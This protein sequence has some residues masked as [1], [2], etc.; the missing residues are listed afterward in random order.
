[1]QKKRSSYFHCL[2]CSII[3]VMMTAAVLSGCYKKEA[4]KQQAS[5]VPVRTAQ[6]KQEDVQL[7]YYFTGKTDSVTVDVVPRIRGYLEECL[8]QQGELVDKGQILYKIEQFDYINDIDN[9]KAKLEIAK[10]KAAN[11]RADYD[12]NLELQ[13]KGAG[14]TTQAD[15]DKTKALWEESVG[16]I[17]SAQATLQ[18]AEKQLERT[19]I[20]AP[21][22]G[23]ISR[24]LIDPGNLV[25]GSTGTPPLLATIRGMD[26]IQV[27]FQVTDTE[28]NLIMS[29]MR[30]FLGDIKKKNP[31][32]ER[33]PLIEIAK[34]ERLN[35]VI[36]ISIDIDGISEKEPFPFKGYIDY[37]DNY[38][39]INTGTNTVRGIIENPTYTIYPGNICRVR[40]KSDYVK[41]SILVDKKAICHDLNN[42][43]VW[44]VDDKNMPSKRV[45]SLGRETEDGRQIVLSGLK[46]GE[47]YII[48]GVLKVRGGVPVKE[49]EEPKEAENNKTADAP[50]QKQN[51]ETADKDPKPAKSSE[52]AKD[53]S[54]AK[55]S[56]IAKDPKTIKND[57]TA[58][59]EKSPVFEN[60]KA[61][62]A[63]GNNSGSAENKPAVSSS[64]AAPA[65]K[66]QKP[67]SK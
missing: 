47:R 8:F 13:K 22:R 56:E 35:D 60:K 66:T 61:E 52:I 3:F 28:F 37:N 19:V 2:G 5:V 42:K 67:A 18:E 16:Q 48:D 23:K 39:D 41:D 62:S 15:L 58:G 40:I 12:R 11:C 45:L 14:F 46:P 33:M 6:V 7:Y 50:N 20:R 63:V 53:P 24:T 44:I 17:D 4:P 54:P 25:D 29:K 32:Y 34:K 49:F 55:T 31:D 59:S 64:S 1:M 51:S 21:I 57:K 30:H 36:D 38:I 27:Y 65:V 10:A 9:A 43:F 26:P